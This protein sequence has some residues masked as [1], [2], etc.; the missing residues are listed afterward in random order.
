M[1][2]Q[3]TID[4]G[5]NSVLLL[6]AQKR[7]NRLEVLCDL[8]RV[9]R[10]GE[11]LHLSRVFGPT[12]M[13]RTL[14][15]LKDYKKLCDQKGVERI[16]AVGTAAFRKASNTP[17]FIDRVHKE[18]G[19]AIR[20][21]SGDEEATLSFQ[22][23]AHDF[24]H[25]GDS[26]V[27]LDI[28][29]GSTEVITST[30]SISL[31]I[32]VV[33]LL[34]TFLKNDPPTDLE[35]KELR[36][37]V[38]KFLSKELHHFLEGLAASPILVGLAGTVTTLSS[39]AQGLKKWDPQKVQGSRLTDKNLEE[40]LKRFLAVPLKRRQEIPGMD[41]DRADTI[42]PGVILLQEIMRV[43]KTPSLLVSD[44]GLRYALL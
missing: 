20:V 21:I 26:L 18:L 11:G 39:V 17:D 31:D 12:A 5:T 7:G 30:Q 38:Q 1:S 13:E 9:S 19:I 25:L 41:P 8:A 4:I 42:I 44:R 37:D 40:L 32:G 14:T 2:P 15:V 10:L 36:L 24:G 23:V 34:E 29:G 22:S 3:A 27:V 28:G 16:L 6:I 33:T 35:V 43:L